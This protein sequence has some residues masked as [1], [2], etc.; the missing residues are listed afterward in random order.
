MRWQPFPL[1]D[2]GHAAGRR[3]QQIGIRQSHMFL[4]DHAAWRIGMALE[5]RVWINMAV[6]GK[7]N[8]HQVLDDVEPV[9]L[10]IGVNAQGMCHRI[11]DH[12]AIGIGKVDVVFEKIDM[13]KNVRRHQQIRN[14]R[15]AVQQKGEAR[16]TVEHNLVD[17]RQP[18][19]AIEVLVLIDLPV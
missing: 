16:I 11:V 12:T 5:T 2:A 8:V 7:A 10:D 14:L 17:F 4:F 6:K 1:H 19:G 3:L 18:H 13:R 9:A 15:V